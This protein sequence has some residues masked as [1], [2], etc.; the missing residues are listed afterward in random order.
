MGG[1]ALE[2]VLHGDAGRGARVEA[3]EAAVLQGDVVVMTD[4]F[5]EHGAD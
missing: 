5:E 1:Q 3:S 4:Q 2:V